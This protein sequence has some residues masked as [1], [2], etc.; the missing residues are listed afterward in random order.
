MPPDVAL[1]T[2]FGPA[3]LAH[4]D[5]TPGHGAGPV[6][7]SHAWNMPLL[8]QRVTIRKRSQRPDPRDPG[9]GRSA[10]GD[11]TGTSLRVTLKQASFVFAS[12][13]KAVRS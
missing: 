7:L 4:A 10:H 8:W 1:S 5:T 2:T 11:R 9:R 13:L 12:P 3:T 6:M